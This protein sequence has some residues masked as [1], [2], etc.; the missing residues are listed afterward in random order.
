VNI[1]AYGVGSNLIG[2][3]SDTLGSKID[4]TMLRYA[5][6]VCPVSCLL[7]AVLLWRG[8]KAMEK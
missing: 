8:G 1:A 5:L 4:P 2:V 3:I 7:A 6:L